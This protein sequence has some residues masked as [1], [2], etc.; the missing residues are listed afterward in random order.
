VLGGSDAAASYVR[1]VR[2]LRFGHDAPGPTRSERRALRRQLAAGLGMLGTLRAWW[3]LPPVS[4]G[5]LKRRLRRPYTQ[6]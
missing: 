3:A 6:K 2:D 1:A 5:A 4:P